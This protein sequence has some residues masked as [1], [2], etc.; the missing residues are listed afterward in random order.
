[1]AK[2]IYGALEIADREIRLIIGEYFNTR[3]NIIRVERENCRGISD[4]VIN[5]KDAV[6]ETVK[7]LV[8]K[9]AKVIGADIERLILLL[10]SVNFKRY[11]L[12]VAVKTQSGI[13]NKN[14][15]ENA[16]SKAMHTNI[17][18]NI[19]II[20]AVCVKYTCNG[21]TYRRIPEREVADELIV[22]IDLLCADKSIGF[23]YVSI[24]EELNIE[25]LDISLDMYAICKE[26]ALFEQTVNQ[27]IILLKIDYD[28]TSLALVSKGKLVNC[29][30]LYDGL[31]SIIQ[32]VLDKY[33][34]PFGVVD[35]LVKYNAHFNFDETVNN[36][37]FAWKTSDGE[38][39]TISEREL[40]SCI[41]NVTDEFVLKIKDA[42]EPIL[43]S[44]DTEIVIVSE[45]AKMAS[46]VKMIEEVTKA[47][48]KAYFP[49]TLGG[50][51]SSLTALLGSIY[52]YHD[53]IMINGNMT[54]SINLLQ[55]SELVERKTND[56]EGETLTT[57]IKNLF[58]S[59]NRG[60]KLDE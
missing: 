23:D 16:I 8:D 28:T 47:T 22:D 21:I 31:N 32:V 36:S 57:R 42:C 29:D 13:I 15:V 3:F 41:K 9:A 27:N 33:H 25:V 17:D 35:R 45:G 43:E 30:I 53:S 18:R 12:K 10:P 52:G 37:I 7:S 51:D 44:G 11:P 60:G 5:N 20:N 14:D 1:M 2:E 55:F 19:L 48:T 59:K 54:S 24:L 49:E 46:L 39:K 34:L 40:S 26:A 56:T 38:S 50:R 4:F 6:K 58:D